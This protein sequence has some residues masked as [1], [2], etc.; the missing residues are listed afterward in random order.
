M[1]SNLELHTQLLFC[2]E[3]GHFK[4]CNISK[5]TSHAPVLRK[6][7]AEDELSLENGESHAREELSLGWYK[8]RSQ[9]NNLAGDL[10]GCPL[11]VQQKWV[12]FDK[13]LSLCPQGAL[14]LTPKSIQKL[15]TFY[16]PY[17][18]HSGPAHH[19]F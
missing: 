4:T 16:R 17:C 5:P 12:L 9:D 10:E 2:N 11:E 18:L 15:T 6:E 1:V 3:Y 7:V 13:S 14:T 19:H 8:G